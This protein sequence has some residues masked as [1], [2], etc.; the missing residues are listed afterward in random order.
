M[1]QCSRSVGIDVHGAELVVCWLDLDTGQVAEGR[2]AHDTRGLRRLARFALEG[3]S[4]LVQACYEAGQWGF[5]LARKLAELGLPTAVIAP[6]LIPQRPGKRAKTD[7]RDARA[8]A[9]LFAC[10]QL[11]E[12]TPPTPEEEAAREVV[13][14]RDDARKALHAARQQLVKLL[15]RWGYQWTGPGRRWTQKY[16]AWVKGIALAES[17]AQRVLE[18]CCLRVEQRQAE[19]ARADRLVREVGESERWREPVSR[20]RCYRGIDLLTA[21]ALVTE[22][23]QVARFGSA[24]EAM[25]W[26]GLVPSERSSGS[27][28]R[29]GGITKAGSKLIRRLLV[30][31]GRHALRRPT[32]SAALARR[33]EGQPAAVIVRADQAM[34]RLYRRYWHL[35]MNGKLPHVA[36]VAVARELMGFVWAELRAA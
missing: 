31:A 7:R 18:E 20:L 3:A 25:S 30:E 13:R 12:V 29:R 9:E 8:L 6:S 24:R 34:T 17:W 27:R 15:V 2:F 21:V 19:L 10:G 22:L 11:V 33:R 16:W 28:E 32:V 35:L 5:E 23:Y 4:G 36:T 26:V 14:S 1:K